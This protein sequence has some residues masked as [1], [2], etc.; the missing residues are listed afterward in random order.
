MLRKAICN[1][2]YVMRNIWKKVHMPIMLVTRVVGD[3]KESFA[4]KII[5]FQS[6]LQPTPC[7]VKY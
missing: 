6:R 7:N 4:F 3:C 2:F 1:M 5:V